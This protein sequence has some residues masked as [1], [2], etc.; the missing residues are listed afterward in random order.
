MSGPAVLDLEIYRGDDYV[1]VLTFVDDS[2]PP[3]PLDISG[4]TF[5]AQI[6]D[7]SEGGILY[8]DFDVDDSDA[9][10]GVLVLS[11]TSDTSRVPTGY[12][13]L[14]ANDGSS[15]TTWLRGSVKVAGDI[16]RGDIYG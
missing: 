13:D 16:T 14:E 5:I 10:V 9:N 1:H 7:R 12:W 2:I 15:I 6:R 4:Y 8:A 3:E 11:L